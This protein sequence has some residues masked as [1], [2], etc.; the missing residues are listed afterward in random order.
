[1]LWDVDA[2]A[3]LARLHAD[4]TDPL[5]A[6]LPR[7]DRVLCYGGGAPVVNAYR[8]LGARDCTLV[9][10]ALDPTTHHPVPVAVEPA[11]D[12]SLLAN[13]LPDREERID[14]FFFRAAALLPDRRFL[15]GGNGWHDKAMPANV[16]WVGHVGTEQH[17]A[18]NCASTAV[19]NVTRESMAANGWSPATR[20][21]E[22]AGAGACLITDAWEGIDEFLEPGREVLV[23]HDG[24]EVAALLEDLDPERAFRIGAAARARV[25]ASHTYADRAAQVEALLLG[26]TIAG[27]RA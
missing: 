8:A 15:L 23:A 2:P 13:R 9:Y 20:V 24:G 1:L 10:N 11:A 25:L 7:Y 22:A 17:N 21:F 19:L 14:E 12:L 18:F 3:T 5:R 4:H 26:R 6:L 16:R 27:A